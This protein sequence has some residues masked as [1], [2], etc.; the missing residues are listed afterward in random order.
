[1]VYQIEKHVT[2]S[3][4]REKKTNS[5]YLVTCQFYANGLHNWKAKLLFL[6]FSG[7]FFHCHFPDIYP[8]E[9]QSV[10]CMCIFA[11]HVSD[12]EL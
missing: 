7:F 1:M 3:K 12:Y 6:S 2:N 4:T 10:P 11:D 8:F 5:K 9:I